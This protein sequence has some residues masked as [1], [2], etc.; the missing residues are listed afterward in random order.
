MDDGESPEGRPASD[1]AEGSA[2][3]EHRD[4]EEMTN[5]GGSVGAEK[6]GTVHPEPRPSSVPP[7]EAVAEKLPGR[8]GPLERIEKVGE[9]ALGE[10]CRGRGR[11]LD[12]G[13][14]AALRK[15]GSSRQRGGG[16]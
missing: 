1:G 16:G 8:W 11:R 14:G 7:A 6:T 13:G 10:T 3:E 9:G 15:P 2:C 12:R 4:L 5:L